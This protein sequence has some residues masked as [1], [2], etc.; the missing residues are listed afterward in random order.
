MDY[1]KASRAS[2]ETQACVLLTKKTRCVL[3][4]NVTTSMWKRCLGSADGMSVRATGACGHGSSTETSRHPS[5]ASGSEEASRLAAA[6]SPGAASPRWR[7]PEPLRHR[8]RFSP[9]AEKSRL[10]AR[11]R[12]EY[13]QDCDILVQHRYDHESWELY[14]EFYL[15]PGFEP[16][17]QNAVKVLR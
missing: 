7:A 9:K 6:S 14:V 12:A 13:P 11:G 1:A 4:C 15:P 16:L 8:L 5:F 2:C 17:R 3:V 10:A